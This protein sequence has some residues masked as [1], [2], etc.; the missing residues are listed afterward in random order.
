MTL[1]E[2]Y[3]LWKD[4]CEFDR[5]QLGNSALDIAKLHHKYYQIL[6]REKLTL[7][8]M[9]SDL[10]RLKLDKYEFYIDGP[11]QEQIEAGWKLPPKGRILKTDVN[12]YLEADQDL[13]KMNLKILYQSEKIDLLESIIKMVMNRG[14]QINS[15]IQWAKFQ[16]GVV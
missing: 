13:I 15:A 5:S 2:I 7:R 6:S 11:T 16:N 1:E 8:K 12:M 14:F 10:K 9:E 4:D 3:D